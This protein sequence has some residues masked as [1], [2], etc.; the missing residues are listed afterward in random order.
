M[1]NSSSNRLRKSLSYVAGVLTL[2][3]LS[4]A[5]APQALAAK[6]CWDGKVKVD[7]DPPGNTVGDGDP[8]SLELDG[9]EITDESP[10]WCDDGATNYVNVG[11]Y[12]CE[13]GSNQV[14]IGMHA[15][16]D[17]VASR[18]KDA[19]LCTVL[20]GTFYPN[21]PPPECPDSWCHIPFDVDEYTV[22][23]TESCADGDCAM[24]VR[25]LISDGVSNR[26]MQ[27]SDRFEMI[28]FGTATMAEGTTNP[29]HEHLSFA[30]DWIEVDFKKPGSTRT[31]VT[32]MWGPIDPDHA[33]VTSTATYT[34]N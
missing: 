17:P 20:S 12:A 5:L 8:A 19:G 34:E 7:C 4:M 18:K 11:N 25:L 30:V 26:T 2:V 3:L 6:P 27:K 31:L 23:W 29:F 16:G 1:F 33:S 15:M 24:E 9:T 21:D 32:C 14:V 22:G 28:L 10:R 13:T